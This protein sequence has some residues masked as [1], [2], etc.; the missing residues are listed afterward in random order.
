T[1]G[2]GHDKDAWAERKRDL[3]V[4]SSARWAG[5]IT[6]ARRDQW[7][8]AR[9][10]QYAH[11]QSL[12]VRIATIQ[13]RL[14]QPLKSKGSKRLPGGYK[15]RQQGFQKARRLATLRAH[16]AALEADY[17]AGRVSVVRG[18]KRL[19]HKRHHLGQSGLT[20]PDWR[21]DWTAARSFLEADGETGKR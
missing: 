11:I 5:S 16:L 1:D 21:A 6:K 2:L 10:A 3:T 4:E 18:G 7:G 12:E 17:A 20:E 13:H 9:R 15:P 19:L 14:S 8:L